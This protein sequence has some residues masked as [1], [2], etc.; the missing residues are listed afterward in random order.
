MLVEQLE[1]VNS[2]AVNCQLFVAHLTPICIN[3]CIQYITTVKASVVLLTLNTGIYIVR[4]LT[5]QPVK[6]V[7]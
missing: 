7:I 4:I 3:P 1:L 6:Q 2:D 5:N